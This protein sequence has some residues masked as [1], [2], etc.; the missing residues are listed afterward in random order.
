MARRPHRLASPVSDQ[1]YFRRYP[2][3]LVYP[4]QFHRHQSNELPHRFECRLRFLSPDIS[5]SH[6]EAYVFHLWLVHLDFWR[7]FGLPLFT[8]FSTYLPSIS[9]SRFTASPTL[10]SRRAVTS[11]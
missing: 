3:Q 1:S 6:P 9:A 11:K 7:I 8:N 10:R 5:L 2:Q 4:P